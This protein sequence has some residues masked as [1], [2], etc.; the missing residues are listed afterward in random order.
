MVQKTIRSRTHR[1]LHPEQGRIDRVL[2]LFGD[3]V[4]FL[5]PLLLVWLRDREE[6][7]DCLGRLRNHSKQLM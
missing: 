3:P 2:A 7:D 5:A 4:V 6:K 1:L